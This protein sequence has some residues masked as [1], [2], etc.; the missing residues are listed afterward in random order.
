MYPHTP[1]FIWACYLCTCKTLYDQLKNLFYSFPSVLITNRLIIVS[2]YHRLGDRNNNQSCKDFCRI[3]NKQTH[4]LHISAQRTN[5]LIKTK[6]VVITN[7]C[8]VLMFS[9]H[10][11]IRSPY[12]STFQ[13]TPLNSVTPPYKQQFYSFRKMLAFYA[14][15]CH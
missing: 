2:V 5:K 14:I 3:Q 4:Y 13:N 7:W 1:M 10:K 11:F 8:S 12:L 6:R 15:Q 9:V